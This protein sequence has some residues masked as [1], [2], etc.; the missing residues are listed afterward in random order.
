M[1]ELP[2]VETVATTLRRFL[3]GAKV[4]ECIFRRPD[5]RE[6]IPQH[7]VRK[8]LNNQTIRS[9]KRRS[10]YII[11]ETAKGRVYFH[12][13]M[14]GKFLCRQPGE[15]PRKHAHITFRVKRGDEE[16]CLD[17][18]DPRRFGRV[19][20]ELGFGE[21]SSHRFF[22]ELGP[23]P[24]ET[25]DLA[26]I[27]FQKSRGRRTP[28]KSFI[29]DAGNVVGV[30]NIYASESLYRAGIHPLSIAK[31]LELSDFRLLVRCLKSVLNAAIK[32]GGTTFSDF[33]NAD[34]DVGYFAVSLKVYDQTD[35]P[36]EK[37][38]QAIRIVRISG[39]SSFFC[40]R[41]QILK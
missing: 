11:M 28:I 35:K 12:L 22:S 13:G 20:A 2:E 37:C 10:K 9:V 38:N 36:C 23:E 7:M 5:L 39:R 3:D 32:A 6:A 24:L 41:C 15:I 40:P 19:D 30:G 29:M 18:D 21:L 31:N 1:P 34:G 8:V 17:F 14:T 16:F 26:G 27:L 25:R 4:K 33:V